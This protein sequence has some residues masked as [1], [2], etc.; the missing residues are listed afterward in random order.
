MEK[1]TTFTCHDILKKYPGIGGWHY[2]HLNEQTTETI[3]LFSTKKI[4][5]GYIPILAKLGKTEWKTTLF[6]TKGIFMLAIQ[7][8]VRKK[9]NVKEGDHVEVSFQLI[10]S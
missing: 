8:S 6:P 4:G 3:K 10:Q 1:T 9:E 2:I 5:W 7:A